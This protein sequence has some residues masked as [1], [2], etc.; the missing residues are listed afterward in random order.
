MVFADDIVL[1]DKV[2]ENVNKK[3]EQWK[4][5]LENKVLGQLEVRLNIYMQVV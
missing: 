1:I 2:S 3:L 5:T 4:S